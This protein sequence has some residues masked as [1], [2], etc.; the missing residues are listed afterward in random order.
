[1]EAPFWPLAIALVVA[2]GCSSTIAS[3]AAD[4]RSPGTLVIAGGAVKPGNA[5]VFGAFIDAIPG[6]GR[7][8]VISAASGAPVESAN[9]FQ[10][11][12]SSRGIDS[13]RVVHVRLAVSDDESTPLVDE[14]RWAGNADDPD[15]IAKIADA[16]AVWFTGGDQSRLTQV[17]L[18]DDGRATPLLVRIRERHAVGAAIG[19]TSAGAAIMSDPMITGGETLATLLAGRATGE[20]L[21]TGRGL[22]F[23]EC[24]LV[25]Q[26]FDARSRLG[27]LAVALER[28]DADCRLGL[29]IDEDTA[30]VFDPASRSAMIAGSGGVTVIDAR[31]AEW[32]HAESGVSVRG[33]VVSVLSPGDRFGL[34]SGRYENADYL[35]PTVGNEYNDTP[36]VSAGGIAVPFA[37]LARLLGEQLLDNEGAASLDSYSV[38]IAE[39]AGQESAVSGAGVLYRFRQADDSA[40]YWGYDENG[41]SRYSSINVR[42]DI[43]P[44]D[45]TVRAPYRDQ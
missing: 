8:A 35:E 15:E 44:V 11:A 9:R 17:L 13:S 2:S 27:R 10:Q 7:I 45:L 26:H 37:G 24:G 14:R 42:L 43:I 33:I 38:F 40:G 18:D 20:R 41:K 34:E 36:P 19:G 30:L 31:A 22:G 4:D 1:M 5:A 39:T 6:D 16:D 25:D 23:F 32:Q 21:S 29:G 3:E 12:L 28:V